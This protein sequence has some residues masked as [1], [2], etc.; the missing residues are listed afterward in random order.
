M[1]TLAMLLLAPSYLLGALLPNPDYLLFIPL[2]FW[3]G[4]MA[5]LMWTS[6]FAVIGDAVPERHRANAMGV[7]NM[8]FMIGAILGYLFAGGTVL[9]DRAPASALVSLLRFGRGGHGG[10]GSVYLFPRATGTE[11]GAPRGA[12][13][14]RPP[15]S[16]H[17]RRAYS[18]VDD[19][20]SPNLRPHA[21]GAVYLPLCHRPGED[22]EDWDST[23]INCYC[24]SACPCWDW[25]SSPSR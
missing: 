18:A 21:A 3:D 14:R 16:A 25:Q 1:I 12:S 6:V 23:G 11:C 5:A 15:A 17:A 13:G 9:L 2:R 19:H 20:L 24:S 22:P 4:A 8:S 7:I 10:D